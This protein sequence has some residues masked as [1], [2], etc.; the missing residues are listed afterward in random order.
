MQMTRGLSADDRA[1]LY[2]LY[3]RGTRLITMRDIDG[4]VDCF[5]PDAVFFL[6]G[7][8]DFG[9]P[10]MTMTGHAELRQFITDTIEGKYDPTMGLEPGTKKRY[11]VG[12]IMLE[13]DGDNGA[14]GSAYFFLILPGK[15]RTPPTLLGTGVYEDSFVKTPDGWKIRKRTLTADV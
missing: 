9:V 3:S 7:I 14:D 6:P 5:T 10:D 13:G 8:E 1:E 4:W 12:N 2:E 15:G 11:L